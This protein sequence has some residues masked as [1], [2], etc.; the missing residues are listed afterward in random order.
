M[1]MK[2]KIAMENFFVDKIEFQEI[3]A[4]CPFEMFGLKFAAH[5]GVGYNKQWK[6]SEIST[7]FGISKGKTRS[8]AIQNAKETLNR[9]GEEKANKEV[10]K[11]LRR[12]KKLRMAYEKVQE[13]AQR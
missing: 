9:V 8:E 6:V 7:G 3:N 11:Q 13:K 12:Q 4:S 2:I 1:I 5:K 10:K